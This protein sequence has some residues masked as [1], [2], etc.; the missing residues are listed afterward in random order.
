MDR[1]IG[2]M[3]QQDAFELGTFD[4]KHFKFQSLLNFTEAFQVASRI[5]KIEI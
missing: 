3:P 1:Q 2:N 5:L 4:N